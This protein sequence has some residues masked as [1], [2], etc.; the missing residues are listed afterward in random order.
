[1]EKLKLCKNKPGTDAHT[2]L[3]LIAQ[4]YALLASA[5]G[6][7]VLVKRLRKAYN[8]ALRKGYQR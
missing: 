7:P 2:K 6:A 1:M 5:P 3:R 4:I 8:K